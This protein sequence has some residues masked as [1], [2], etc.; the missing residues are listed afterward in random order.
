MWLISYSHSLSNTKRP[1][2]YFKRLT[3][4]KYSITGAAD[5]GVSEAIYLNDPD[6]N[7]VELYWDKP[8]DKWPFDAE[9]NVQMI[10]DAL[11]IELLLAEL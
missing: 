8:K 5:H 2:S 3:D 6:R 11:D 1:C 7:G 4:A 9:G 10:T